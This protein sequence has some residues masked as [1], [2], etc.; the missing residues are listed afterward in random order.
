[1]ALSFVQPITLSL[2]LL[3]RMASNNDDKHKMEEAESSMVRKQ[4]RLSNDDDS[5][6]YFD[7]PERELEEEEEEIE[8]GEGGEGEGEGEEEEVFSEEMSMNQ[9]DTSEEKLDARR[10]RSILFSDDSDTPSTSA[11]P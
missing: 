7:S 3:Q 8:E 11:E 6:D 1:M 10:A 4:L 2:S 9:L 5:F